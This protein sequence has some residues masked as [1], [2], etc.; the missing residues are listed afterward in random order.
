M[1]RLQSRHSSGTEDKGWESV[2]IDSGS[3]QTPEQGRA[4][5]QVSGSRQPAGSLSHGA[6]EA[7]H[8]DWP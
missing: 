5:Q 7:K 1:Q 2:Q 8:R 6:K 4:S 3:Q